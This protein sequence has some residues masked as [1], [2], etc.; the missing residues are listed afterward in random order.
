[1]VLNLLRKISLEYV[2]GEAV[3]RNAWKEVVG[4][5]SKSEIIVHLG[6]MPSTGLV[7]VFQLLFAHA[8]T[9]N[10]CSFYLSSLS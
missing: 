9:G 10:I 3:R 6:K 8:A 4:A 5:S 2:A 7:Q 1:M